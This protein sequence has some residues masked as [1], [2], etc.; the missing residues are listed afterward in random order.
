MVAESSGQVERTKHF[1]F[2]PLEMVQRAV[3]APEAAPTFSTMKGASLML[4]T[5]LKAL[6]SR[7]S[8]RQALQAVESSLL[9]A[10]GRELSIISIE[11]NP[12]RSADHLVMAG[13][14]T[15]LR[16]AA[17]AVGALLDADS[18]S[19]RRD[20]VYLSEAS[21]MLSKSVRAFS[22]ADVMSAREASENFRLFVPSL[23]SRQRLA[24]QTVVFWSMTVAINGF[25][26]A[27]LLL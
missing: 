22:E 5:T 6:P 15:N 18:E 17:R 12:I 1:E 20:A 13:V 7:R 26:T 21:D 4:S 25:F 19:I 11:M 14:I 2:S 27:R 3:K 10:L 24:S 16:R 9:E 8:D 23:G